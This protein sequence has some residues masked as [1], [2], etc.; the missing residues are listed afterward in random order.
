[1][2]GKRAHIDIDPDYED[3]TDQ[4]NKRQRV[5]EKDAK[6]AAVKKIESIVKT[7]F[8]IEL[9][10]KE[11]E[12]NMVDQRLCQARLM[13]DRLRACIVANFYGSID[14][15][16][17]SL[18][19]TTVQSSIHPAVKSHLGKTVKG[20]PTPQ[21]SHTLTSS[22]VQNAPQ[23]SPLI[24][25]MEDIP[26]TIELKSS[27]NTTTKPV[28][29]EHELRDSRFKIKK[30]IIIGNV[31]KY[32]P[33]EKR[34]T[35]DQSTHKWMVYVRGP[36]DKP[37]INGFVKKIWF[38]LHPSYRPNDL[39]EI[40]Q[41]P[42]HLTR[43]G[44][45]EFPI[46]IQLHFADSRNKKVDVIHHLK[47][48]RTYT[49]LQT[50][51]AETVVDVEL[52]REELT[53]VSIP[54]SVTSCSTDLNINISN[55][56]KNTCLSDS[57]DE[58]TKTNDNENNILAVQ[59][60]VVSKQDVNHTIMHSPMK[61]TEI[62][63]E[64]VNGNN[65]E[66]Q[67]KN[68]VT[69]DIKLT[70]NTPI[71]KSTVPS[72]ISDTK[73]TQGQTIYLRC[74]DTKGNILLVPKTVINNNNKPVAQKANQMTSFRIRSP[75]ASP[76]RAQNNDTKSLLVQQKAQVINP[77]KPKVFTAPP[78]PSVQLVVTSK[79]L[80]ILP[81]TS[82]VN[83][84]TTPQNTLKTQSLLTLNK[85]NSSSSKPV[86]LL[87]NHGNPLSVNTP[88]LQITKDGLI[89]AST[90]S[91]QNVPLVQNRNQK[92]LLGN[93]TL[94]VSNQKLTVSKPPVSKPSP[95]VM[96][97]SVGS[98]TF[99][100]QVK[101]EDQLN[102]SQTA[103]HHVKPNL[104][105]TNQNLGNKVYFN[106]LQK[107]V[108]VRQQLNERK[109]KEELLNRLN[110]D[111]EPIPEKR[112]HVWKKKT[113]VEET[114]I[115]PLRLD[116]YNDIISLIKA[117]VKRHPLVKQGIDRYTHPY[118]AYSYEH[119]LGWNIGKRR[120]SEWQRASCV[121]KFIISSLKGDVFKGKQLWSTKQIM[122]WCRLHAFSPHYLE[123]KEEKVICVKTVD[124]EHKAD[125]VNSLTDINEII[126]QLPPDIT[127]S[128]NSDD[129]ID[130]ISIESP[131]KIKVE[132]KEERV[133]SREEPLFL[134]PSDQAIFIQDTC[135]KIGVKLK[136]VD[137]EENVFGSVCEDMMFN[138]MKNFAED[139][140]RK[141]FSY[142]QESDKKNDG[143][144][145]VEDVYQA[146]YNTPVTDFITNSHLGINPTETFPSFR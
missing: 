139:I 122:F 91:K 35:N 42:F 38:F 59:N 20:T 86:S 28:T 117:A 48:D 44:W 128:D 6:E 75:P 5:L 81:Q 67:Q 146:L 106:N 145:C 24:S 97:A 126:I 10:K 55:L 39:V 102:Q 95:S 69:L 143:T 54:K 82:T 135:Q 1:M 132:V 25:K 8:G 4:Q 40:C 137:L 110:C 133:L 46:R 30:R 105:I 99:L 138:A 29:N 45:G 140:L 63:K 80:Q 118:C 52:E 94:S 49:G 78:K 107:S 36:K 60:G 26:K 33:V 57:R 77:V 2:S 136:P 123:R 89:N 11:H 51:G 116:D 96:L 65:L 113:K 71:Q 74:K 76:S 18:K 34:E 90:N 53:D 19:S 87:L 103:A 79:G 114:I 31:A 3:V 61:R 120:A 129:D 7:Q 85:P 124:R 134:P 72:T 92:S 68:S 144:I 9:Q 98:K 22:D 119:W 15:Q 17:Y 108:T 111:F 27:N 115:D 101:G 47:L 16:K 125:L 43:R 109:K 13:M 121:R 23:D 100:L 73:P 32:I 14:Q 21:P 50:L 131:P 83:S 37:N 142:Q 88:K 127:T 12:V 70:P 64:L 93:T 104:T 112:T 84:I 66:S 141:S 56:N 41:P 62:K 58:I 130:I